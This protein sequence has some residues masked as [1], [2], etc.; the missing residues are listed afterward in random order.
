MLH[1]HM[2]KPLLMLMLEGAQSSWWETIL[3]ST[4]LRCSN[5]FCTRFIT[6]LGVLKLQSSQAHCLAGKHDFVTMT[7][8]IHKQVNFRKVKKKARELLL[9]KA[10]NKKKTCLPFCANP[11]RRRKPTQLLADNYKNTVLLYI[12]QHIACISTKDLSTAFSQ[13]FFKKSG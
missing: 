8:T 4:T 2:I 7:N 3:S 6:I 12:A 11:S 5:G 13:R 10:L 1:A 9:I